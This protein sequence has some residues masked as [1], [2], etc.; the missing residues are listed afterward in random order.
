MDFYSKAKDFINN[1]VNFATAN[2]IRVLE[3]GEGTCTAELT[4]VQESLNPMGNVHGGCL[5]TLADVTCGAA[6]RSYGR[7]CVTL[8]CSLHY[9][10]AGTGGRIRGEARVV[11]KGGTIVVCDVTLLDEKDVKVLVGTLTFYL[12]GKTLS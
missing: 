7:K 10:A 9:L 3:V 1:N 12:L 5:A 2:H 6:V 8:D 4:V 11:R